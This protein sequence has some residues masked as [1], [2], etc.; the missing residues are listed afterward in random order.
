MTQNLTSSGWEKTIKQTAFMEDSIYVLVPPGE[1][2]IVQKI[3][4]K[5]TVP[6]TWVT[7]EMGMV[8]ITIDPDAPWAGLVPAGTKSP[9]LFNHLKGGIN[10]VVKKLK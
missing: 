8:C 1:G 7:L 2:T 10:M 5:H 9:G 6:P 3:E 4:L